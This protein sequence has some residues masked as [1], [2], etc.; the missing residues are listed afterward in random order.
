MVAVRD[1]LNE[2][3][4]ENRVIALH[5]NVEWPPR[6]PGLIPCDFFML[7]YLKNKVF[8]T[9][10]QN[11]DVLRQRIIDEFNV[12]RQQPEMIHAAVCTAHTQKNHGGVRSLRNGKHV[13]GHGP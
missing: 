13:E 1:R 2:V 12:L 11:I 9:P 10:P 4:G 6:S 3:F 7:R 8:A 5:H